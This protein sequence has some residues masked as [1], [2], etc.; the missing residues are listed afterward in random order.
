M[1]TSP[2]VLLLDDDQF[3]LGVYKGMVSKLPSQP[4]VHTATSGARAIALLDSEPFTLLI[5]DLNMPKMDGLQVLSIVR[6]KFPQLRIVVLTAVIDEQFRSRA[7]AM[8]VDLFWQKPGTDQEIELFKECIES[9]LVREV[10]GGFRGIQSKSLVDLIQMEC[11]SQNSAVLKI[12]NG[13]QEGRIWILEGDIIDATTGA[14]MGEEAFREIFSWKTGNFETF[15]AEPGRTRSMFN[16]YQGLLLDTAQSIDESQ[17]PEPESEGEEAVPSAV[18]ALSRFK[19]VEFVLCLPESAEAK[20]DSWGL[21]NPEPLAEWAKK[22]RQ[23]FHTIGERIKAG[24][25]NECVASGSLRFVLLTPKGNAILC[26]GF[27]KA[28]PLDEV[29]E[30]FKAMVVKWTS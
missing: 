19:G 16:S 14:L 15:P 28:L 10:Q 4:E 20:P 13:A 3:L 8:G 6:R 21:E 17:Q 7:Y 2:K 26:A 5:S 22:T 11:L 30:T 25:I 18:A 27:E 23:G 12:T 29:R 9:L 1:P 24:E